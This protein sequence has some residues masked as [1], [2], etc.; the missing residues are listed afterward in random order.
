ME[1]TDFV[2]CELKDRLRTFEESAFPVFKNSLCVVPLRA[3]VAPVLS[4]FS[5]TM[6]WFAPVVVSARLPLPALTAPLTVSVAAFLSVKP[7]PPPVL[8]K[9]FSVPM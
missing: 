5:M 7:P 4:A 6:L 2:C 9:A 8:V 3:N 1:R